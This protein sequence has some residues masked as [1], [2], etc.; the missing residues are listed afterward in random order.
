MKKTINWTFFVLTI[1]VIACSPQQRL[2]HL[3]KKNP[4][5]FIDTAITIHDTVSIKG[6]TI[7]TTFSAS[8]DTIIIHDSIQTITYIYDKVHDK[9]YIKGDVHERLVP[10]TKVITVKSPVVTKLEYKEHW[11]A[12]P[13]VWYF[14]L[15]I[16]YIA[17]CF[18][19]DKYKK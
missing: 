15:S 14:I 17:I 8:N 18:I 6:S 19:I 5:L 4:D 7:D 12:M 10:I 9:V 1:F 3:L 16:S 11:W 2:N 13:L